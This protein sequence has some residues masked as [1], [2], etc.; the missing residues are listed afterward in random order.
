MRWRPFTWFLTGLILL[1]MTVWFWR[2]K[3]GHAARTKAA[4]QA[5]MSG[6]SKA[7]SKS[8]A[9]GQT[10]A[11]RARPNPLVMAELTNSSPLTYRLANTDQSISQLT[12]NQRAILL[13]NALL[14]TSLKTE[15]PIP[16]HLRSH[17]EPGAYIVQA[18]GAVDNALRAKLG[19]VGADIISYIPNNA[20]LVRMSS[21]AAEQ[22]EGDA[23]AVLPYEPYYKIKAGLLGVAIKQMALPE[24]TV[25]QLVLFAQD[26]EAT[27]AALSGMGA[28]VLGEERSP[29]GPVVQ[30]MAPSESLSALAGLPGVQ[31]I[32]PARSRK[33]AND[34][35][36][37]T[38]GVATDTLTGSNYL[39]LTGSNVM[40]SIN[41]TGVDTNHPDF[42]TNGN[43]SRISYDFPISGVDSNGHGTFVAGIIAGSGTNSSTVTNAQGSIMP[44]TNTQFRGKAPAAMIY[45][46]ALGNGSDAYLQE[47]VASQTN[48]LIS[49]NS[50]TYGTIGYD[51][52]AASYD[53]AVRDA[54]P[55]QSGSQPLLYVFPSGNGG[56][57][58]NWDD[59][60][61]DDGNGGTADTVESPGTAKNVITVGAIE[62][63]RNIT[64]MVA[65]T[66]SGTNGTTQTN[67]VTEWLPS[68][69]SGDQVAGFSSCGNVGVQVEGQYGRFKPDLVAP[70]TGLVSTRSTEWDEAAYYNPT[71]YLDYSVT[72]L[73]LT[74]G[75]VFINEVP[76]P[77]NAVGLT[78]VIEPNYQSVLPLPAQVIY[79]DAKG[80][81]TN[82]QFYTVQ[83]NAA[84]MPPA[85]G[86]TL[87]PV[88]QNWFYLVSNTSSS[89]ENFDLFVQVAVT[90]LYGNFLTVLSNMNDSLCSGPPYYYRYDS[91]TSLAAAE[92]SG[93]LALMEEFMENQMQ[94]MFGPTNKPSPAL[95]KAMLI[96]GS[97]PVG[98]QTIWVDPS[99]NQQGWG[100]VNLPNSLPWALTNFAASNSSSMM[101]FDQSPSNALATG[102]SQTRL[103]ATVA[104]APLFVTLVWTDPPGNPVAGVKL[105][106]DLNLLVTNLE[107]G[108]VYWGNDILEGNTYNLPWNTNYP[109]NVDVVNNV[110]NIFLPPVG[111]NFSITVVGNRVNVNA[112]TAQ[113]NDV[114]QDYALVVSTDPALTNGLTL[115]STL[116]LTNGTTI[117]VTNALAP[118]VITPL[119]TTITNMFGGNSNYTGGILLGQ[120]SG[121]SSPLLGTN[122][123]GISNTVSTMGATG[124]LITVGE[125]NQWH[126]YSITNTDGYTNAAF[127]TFNPLTLALPR[128]GVFADSD[129]N[130][131]T[132]EADLDLYVSMD[133][134]LTN[135]SLTAVAGAYKSLTRGGIQMVVLNNASNGVYYIGVQSESGESAEYGF[136]GVFSLLPFDQNQNGNQLLTGFVTP[137]VIAD[138]T[139]AHPSATYFFA[140]ATSEIKLQRVIVTNII[141]HELMGD[142][143]GKLTHNNKSVVLNNHSPD[144]AVSYK[145]YVY[146]DSGEN[147]TSSF[148]TVS[149]TYAPR[150]TDGPG[151]LLSFVG[152]EGVGVWMLTMVDNAA[153]HDGTNDALGIFL[154]K[155]QNPTTGIT[156][157][158]NPGACVEDSVDV[159]LDATN[160]VVTAT[161]EPP[162]TNNA[163]DPGDGPILLTVCP[164][165]GGDCVSTNIPAGY[166]NSGS[167]VI[168]KSSSPPLNLG[169]Y[170]ITSC[171][172][173]PGVV[174]EVILVTFGYGPPPIPTIYHSSG[175][176]PI[177]DDAASYSTIQ[178]TNGG[179][180]SAAPLNIA[181]LEV[182]MR[183]EHPRISD[184]VLHLIDPFGTRILLDEN[185]GG[186]DTNGMGTTLVTTNTINVAYVGGPQP[187]TNNIDTGVRQ[188]SISITYNMYQ[189]PDRMV[190]Y[191]DFG[192]PTQTNLFDTGMVSYNG[193]TNL[194]YGPGASTIVTIIMNPGGNPNPATAWEYDVT[195]AQAN[196][197]YFTFT[198]NTNETVI[199]MKFAPPPFGG[200][201]LATNINLSDF[202]TNAA[203]DYA[204]PAGTVAGWNVISNQVTVVSDPLVAQAGTNYLALANGSISRQLPTVPGETYTLTYWYRGPDIVA[205]WRGE[206]N[207]TDS[208]NGLTPEASLTS[209]VTFTNGEVGQAFSFRTSYPKI[210]VADQP[211]F[212]LTNELSLEA[213]V[214]P[215]AGHTGNYILFRG[216]NRPGNDPYGLSGQSDGTLQFQ[217]DDPN[218]NAAS[219]SAPLPGNNQWMHVAGTFDGYTGELKLYI[220]G[221]VVSSN[222]TTLRP[223]GPLI[224]ADSPGIGIG[225]VGEN[226]N[227][228]PWYGEIDE[229]SI[230]GRALSAS[231]VKAIYSA[232][233]KGKFDPAE[234]N[235]SFASALSKFVM[236]LNGVQTTTYANNTNWQ[237]E[238]V[239]FTATSTNTALELDGIEPG[240]LLDTFVLSSGGLRVVLPEQS[241]AG[242]V[243]TN[244]VGTW[245]L[246]ILDNR[247]GATNPAPMLLDWDLSFIF[248]TPAPVPQPLQHGQVVSGTV[249]PGQ[250]QYYSIAVSNWTPF[251]EN[252]LVNT[253][254][255]GL[256]VWFNQT[257]PPIG[258]NAHGDILL[259]TNS[260]SA[261]VVLATNSVPP[262]VPGATYYI[263]IQNTNSS[264][265]LNY[266][267]SVQFDVTPLTLNVPIAT[268]ESAGP[269]QQY[270]SYLVTSKETGVQFQLTNLTGNVELVAR[271]GLPF[272]TPD[273]EGH[274][275]SSFNPGRPDEE[276][277]VFTNSDPVPL[278]P[279]Q[280]Y[281]GVFNEDTKAV[282]YTIVVTDMTNAVPPII[283]LDGLAGGGAGAGASLA[284]SAVTGSAASGSVTSGSVASRSAGLGSSDGFTMV[285]YT[286]T[287]IYTNHAADYYQHDVGTNATVVEFQLVNPSGSLEMVVSQGIPLPTTNSG[288]YSYMSTNIG[289]NGEAI[290][291]FTNS[292]PVPLEPG[293]WFVGV[294]NTSSSNVSYTIVITED[295]TPVS[296]V[297][298]LT[299]GIPYLNTNIGASGTPDY[300]HYT[301]TPN[302]TAVS[303]QL[304]NLSGD[305][306]LVLS[307][308]LP[309]P[310]A[311]SYEYG[312][313]NPGTRNEQI[314]VLTNSMPVPLS[315]GDWYL[316]VLNPTGTNVAYTIVVN[317]YTNVVPGMITLTNGIPYSPPNPLQPGGEDYYHYVVTSN[318]TLV[319]FRLSNLTDQA[320]LLARRGLPPPELDNF[321][322][323]NIGYNYDDIADELIVVG[324]NSVPVPLTPGDW[325]LSVHVFDIVPMTYTVEA[326]DYVF[327]MLTNG[328]AY[329]ASNNGESDIVDYYAY[330]VG[331]NAARVQFE[332]NSPSTNVALVVT[333]N[334]PLPG[335]NPYD[336]LSDNPGISDQL[337][338]LFKSSQPIALAPGTW[339]L[340]AVDVQ[341]GPAAY[342]IKA[343]EWQTTGTNV[344]LTNTQN[345]TNCF[346]FSWACLPG[347]HYIIDGKVNLTDAGWAPIDVVT[348]TNSQITYCVPINSP[349]HFFRIQEEIVTTTTVAPV[350][351]VV[352][353]STASGM[354]LQWFS[355][356]NVG[357]QVLWTPSLQPANWQVLTNVAN[358]GSQYSAVSVTDS[359]SATTNG[360]PARFYRIKQLP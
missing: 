68:T 334:L 283:I 330:V 7:P 139:S 49:N 343:T 54:L 214:Y 328:V 3:D 72:G 134:T 293:P 232:G 133:P 148:T 93:T 255:A 58:N 322:Y 71:N 202:E 324:T 320:V 79:V 48:V 277:V 315:A 296:Q 111:T 180:N 154:Q 82:G 78:I 198:E 76:I 178:V 221:V 46:I 160:M 104:N 353:T 231:E 316:A 278:A 254:S 32:E 234:T 192:L 176:Q 238:S 107:T 17:E 41:D 186:T 249:C 65:L 304:T 217:I 6:V 241:M 338:T 227:Q 21:E 166:T 274:D 250:F 8:P 94:P 309:L 123:L 248:Q 121:A 130:S 163:A 358:T 294:F 289:T 275:Y 70:G 306:N 253:N 230:Y 182:G 314:V 347:V 318:E 86:T 103:V 169:T 59:G 50:W 301:V 281:L 77:T 57:M 199:P 37:V 157:Y 311:A 16:E 120:H 319:A 287:N 194:N 211:M 25:L 346:C 355:A 288:G 89:S 159:P 122:M 101:V 335:L 67:F 216:D 323:I 63:F 298:N 127:V 174:K 225:N 172:N 98:G 105:V 43:Q 153:G 327:T 73:T 360:P 326:Y 228:F 171:N 257:A 297:I 181:S 4:T 113:T 291:V 262:L 239:T 196:Y 52:A 267:F 201:S 269:L 352:I 88:D 333:T 161:I 36:R 336:L 39:G 348:A 31:E 136:I 137:Q 242:E 74:N 18:R 251:V 240:V 45:S 302:E 345:V 185:R 13:E 282:I 219:V 85:G 235:A 187:Q 341:G 177:P 206:D 34:I 140:L 188:G 312:S 42:W 47:T 165:S 223:V 114:V 64:N 307:K 179:I 317:D 325:Y 264:N 132:P 222:I 19:Q 203:G 24:G 92:V 91:G 272:P 149:G 220:N 26:R 102:Q 40:V 5:A 329:A 142:L 81:P 350:G 260:G 124:G 205:M 270:F 61:N 14:D 1:A 95:M 246:E 209:G 144:G 300:Y 354:S 292:Q 305:V 99:V 173:G 44:G 229:A 285:S 189:I 152:T 84:Y 349:Y 158:I 116:T 208:I 29:F 38:L 244:A 271:R 164:Q 210:A 125:T 60:A 295:T 197:L 156:N 112:V 129:A 80:Y 27:E 35:S 344:V 286:T 215:A 110:E 90:N 280:W 56:G 258:T 183:I 109:P 357:F 218:N 146:D 359:A 195:S 108:A 151:S 332:I 321:D 131:T 299:N 266:A 115:A 167:V 236:T 96:N 75:Q 245:Q 155:Q 117:T 276:I 351:N 118:A 168:S 331:P 66:Y 261:T 100:L 204:A 265:C 175:P 106:N 303:F 162:D 53:A 193:T 247:V 135:L 87:T 310:S 145:A 226:I 119:L 342:S 237:Q 10:Q 356:P 33:A 69:D 243:G 97:V 308:D 337:I 212:V 128:M 143:Q 20:L 170:T 11:E 55:L 190:V 83:T 340:A 259:L 213:W 233:S 184:L 252:I 207:Y 268:N 191:Y 224:A 51:L 263:G 256:N 9:A 273:A 28:S 15:L 141:S 339:Y 313:F 138:G 150:H 2:V 62:Q 147:N 279:G 290:I 126:F 23:Q 200:S 284:G 30:V 12:R 22:L